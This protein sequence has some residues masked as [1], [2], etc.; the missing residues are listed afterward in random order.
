MNQLAATIP[1]SSR[2]RLRVID[3]TDNEPDPAQ[4][5]L[6]KMKIRCTHEEMDMWYKET[7]ELAMTMNSF[8][9]SEL[10]AKC[11][12]MPHHPNNWGALYKQLENMGYSKD[13]TQHRPS[14]S[15]DANGRT[16]I[17]WRKK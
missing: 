14:P 8:Y 2:R 9:P 6:F 12:R 16:E 3:C 17:I 10:Y 13:W 1:I 7:L 15:P 5:D 4:M 11:A